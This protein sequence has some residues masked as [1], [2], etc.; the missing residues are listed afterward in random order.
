[1]TTSETPE[2]IPLGSGFGTDTTAMEVLDGVELSGRT[3]LVTGGYSGIGLEL[4]RALT[5]AGAEV[6]IPARRPEEASRAL[7]GIS[8]VQVDQMDLADPEQ[9]QAY[10]EQ[11]VASDRSVDLVIT[12]AGIMACPESRTPQGWESQFATNHLGHYAL[13]NR[14]WPALAEGARIV[15]VSSSGHH[16]S[17]IRWED[18]WFDEGYDKWLA[19]GQSKTANI[20]FALGLDQRAA[21]HP[22]GRNITAFSL[23]P[24]AIL[25][26]LG[27]H[28]DRDDVAALMEPD[29]NGVVQIPEFK[30]P[31]AGAATAA[32]AA[33]SPLLADHPGS[34]LA[35]CDIAPWAE[36]PDGQ[37]TGGDGHGVRR[38]A[39]DPE[40]AERLWTWSAELT[41]VD[42]LRR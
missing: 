4:V 42:A 20:L 9:V 27:R 38:Y 1:M 3:A 34:F 23:H 24:G 11:V 2:Q 29:E 14:V 41:G 12:N 13:V 15:S 33:T 17:P 32:W 6:L 10:A 8:G 30:S 36:E 19:Y 31:Q 39:L 35:D 25:T 28:L 40:Q 22:D 26:N 18:P 7:A 16:Y 21:A 5:D 37:H